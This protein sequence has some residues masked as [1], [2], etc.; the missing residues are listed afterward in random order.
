MIG[1]FDSVPSDLCSFLA[2]QRLKP[3]NVG[4]VKS[5]FK[6]KGGA[7]GGTIAS[8]LAMMNGS[9]DDMKVAANPFALSPSKFKM[10]VMT[11]LIDELMISM[12]VP[13]NH[14]PKP[15]IVE[16]STFRGEKSYGGFFIMSVFFHLSFMR[17]G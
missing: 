17:S 10:S 8:G 7:S 1:G 5:L 14:K 3:H 15:V 13:G 9:K 12:I 6:V 4:E 11:L 2:V 16:S